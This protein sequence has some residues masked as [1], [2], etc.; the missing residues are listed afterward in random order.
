MSAKLRC[1]TGAELATGTG[2]GQQFR[3]LGRA[4]TPSLPFEKVPLRKLKN[5]E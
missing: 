4:T 1:R 5:D 2:L 3:R